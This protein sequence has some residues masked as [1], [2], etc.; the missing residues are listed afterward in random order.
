MI[1]KFCQII[2]APESETNVYVCVSMCVFK[3]CSCDKLH[4]FSKVEVSSYFLDEPHL[5]INNL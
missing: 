3:I 5:L 1:V 2:F 4:G